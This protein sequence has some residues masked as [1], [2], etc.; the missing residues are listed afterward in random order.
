MRLRALKTAGKWRL[1]ALVAL[2]GLAMAATAAFALVKVYS[3]DFSKATKAGQLLVEGKGCTKSWDQENK[4]LDLVAKQGPARCRLKVP[5]QADSPQPNQVV[6][7]TAK[8][9]KGIDSAVARKTYIAISIRDGAGGLLEMRVYPSLQKVEVHREPGANGFPV[10]V[11]DKAIGKPGD[12]NFLRIEANEDV[13]KVK[14]NKAK[15]DAIT[16]P[17]PAELE[18]RRI[19]LQLVSEAKTSEPIGAWFDDLQVQ[20]PNP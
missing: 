20:V 3:N 18:G 5:V 7:V 17:N 13:I 15:L 1:A 9:D 12:R 11:K 14:V 8:L 19:T 16:D 6:L 2:A 10:E 4:R